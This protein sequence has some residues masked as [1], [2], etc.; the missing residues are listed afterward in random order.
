MKINV[1]GVTYTA[2]K[3]TNWGP[4]ISPADAA[5]ILRHAEKIGKSDEI[6]IRCK[7]YG[8]DDNEPDAEDVEA[9]LAVDPEA[10]A[11]VYFEDLEA[12][13]DFAPD[14]KTFE[15]ETGAE[16]VKP[17]RREKCAEAGKEVRALMRKELEAQRVELLAALES[18]TD[19]YETAMNGKYDDPDE[20]EV[21]D[22]ARAAIA[23]AGKGRI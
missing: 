2:T 11:A 5:C 20:A 3:G 19:M 1:F 12:G 21:I 13:E 22:K 14:H 18:I 6:S 10:W 8:Q 9:G 16:K 23:R 7:E 17:S 4:R 15:I